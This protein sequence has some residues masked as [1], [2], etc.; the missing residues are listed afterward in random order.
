MGDISKVNVLREKYG[1]LCGKST[2]EHDKIFIR[3]LINISNTNIMNVESP[4]EYPGV[5]LNAVHRVVST[6]GYYADDKLMELIR[7]HQYN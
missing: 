7:L 6:E 4:G 1:L 5:V 2:S 3:I